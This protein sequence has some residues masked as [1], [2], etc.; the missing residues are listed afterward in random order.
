MSSFK[1]QKVIEPIEAPFEKVV[2]R[3][4]DKP[5]PEQSFG[6]PFP[7]HYPHSPLRYPGGKNRAVKSIYQCI[8]A[9]EKVLCSPFLGEI[10]RAHV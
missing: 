4:L 5:T 10:G 1:L 7:K 8:P 9:T 6:I 2:A 3:V